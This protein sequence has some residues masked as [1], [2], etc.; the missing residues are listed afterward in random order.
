MVE[1]PQRTDPMVQRLLAGKR[2]DAHGDYSGAHFERCLGEAFV[3]ERRQE[4]PSGERVLYEAR[5]L[6]V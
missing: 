6:S 1:F 5:P 3:V 2:E 4:L